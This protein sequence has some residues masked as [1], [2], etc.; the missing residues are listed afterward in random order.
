MGEDRDPQ[1]QA[2][3]FDRLALGLVDGHGEC[4]TNRELAAGEP[5]RQLLF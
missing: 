3:I 1:V 2:N 5:N 4:N